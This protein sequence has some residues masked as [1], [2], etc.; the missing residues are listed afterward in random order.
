MDRNKW[1]LIVLGGGALAL[2]GLGVALLLTFRNAAEELDGGLERFN[3]QQQE[4]GSELYTA[5][6]EEYVLSVGECSV[7]DAN[8]TAS[9]TLRNASNEAR[10]FLIEVAF[11]DA[12]GA[13]V[14][15]A[16]TL[17]PLVEPN[18]AQPF[19]IV[20]DVPEAGPTPS[21]VAPTVPRPP[22]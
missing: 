16:S 13:Q 3:E 6:P 4:K 9:G 8:A 22:R 10:L 12:S 14:A 15:D 1:I 7:K 20:A 18:S 11:T 2:V 17:T 21:G 5:E 19:T